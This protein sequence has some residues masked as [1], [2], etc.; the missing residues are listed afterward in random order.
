MQIH[1]D[2]LDALLL[3]LKQQGVEVRKIDHKN[4]PNFK[5]T[6]MGK[7]TWGYINGKM[8][9]FHGNASVLE[10]QFKATVND[11]KQAYEEQ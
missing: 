4:H 10:Q 5:F 1:V 9:Q 3:F 7:P 2:H 6:Y 8:A 11:A